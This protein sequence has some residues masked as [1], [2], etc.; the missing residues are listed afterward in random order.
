MLQPL[1]GV[2]VVVYF[3]DILVYSKTLND[4]VN[5][6]QSVFELLKRNNFYANTKK[7]TFEVSKVGFLGYVV[8]DK[9][10]AMDEGKVKAIL[11]LPVPR[12][13]AEMRSFHGLATFYRRFIKGFSTIAAPLID[14][15]KLSTFA[16]D[17]AKQQSFGSLKA[18]LT[19]A[20]VLQAPDL[21]KIFELDCDAS[22]VG[23]GGVL[24]QEGKP[25]AY[26][27][28]KLN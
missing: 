1:L 27:S 6:L 13:V 11:D 16:C 3:D 20:T 7:F 8:T 15:L 21:E 22:R 4:H 2:C 24:S 25:V 18:T 26:F 23:I 28:E 5:H 12:S 9:G 19:A 10:I 14:C 17:E